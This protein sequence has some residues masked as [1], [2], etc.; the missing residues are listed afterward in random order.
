MAYRR[1]SSAYPDTSA[2]LTPLQCHGINRNGARCS[3]A[4]YKFCPSHQGQEMWLRASYITAAQREAHATSRR[5]CGLTKQYALC[6]NN[7]GGNFSYCWRHGDQAAFDVGPAPEPEPPETAII[8][9]RMREFFR[10]W[11]RSEEA[12]QEAR[13]QE[14]RRR[15]RARE[16][17]EREEQERRREREERWSQ[18]EQ[19]TKHD[20]SQQQHQRQ[21]SGWWGSFFQNEDGYASSDTGYARREEQQRREEKQRQEEQQAREEQRRREQREEKEREQRRREQKREQERA[22]AQSARQEQ[23]PQFHV[24]AL[25]NFFAQSA[26]FDTTVFSDKNRNSF[27]RIPWPVFRRADG[28]VHPRDITPENIRRFWLQQVA[29]IQDASRNQSHAIKSR[30]PVPFRS[31]QSGAQRHFEYCGQ[32]RTYGGVASRRDSLVGLL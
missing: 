32:S 19:N 5:C 27:S 1:R 30:P 15:E 22:R 2:P 8:R 11:R 7:P 24:T 29:T 21:Q 9:E 14:Q 25:Q 4:H 12:A 23:D 26:A 31:I 18:E 13:Y 6:R 10:L 16:R 3:A 20:R 28:T 17:A